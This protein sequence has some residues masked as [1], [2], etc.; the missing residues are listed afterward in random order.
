MPKMRD[1]TLEPQAGVRRRGPR[2]N[3][4]LAAFPTLEP[5]A[6]RL[7]TLRLERG[8]S[9]RALAARARISTNHYQDIAHAHANP[10]VIV[11][12]QLADAL[13]VQVAD[14]FDSPVPLADAHRRVLVTDLAELAAAHSRLTDIVERIAKDEMRQRRRLSKR[15]REVDAR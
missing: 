9:Q 2:Q 10:S 8:Y 1:S 3:R 7:E 6:K 15:R 12:L 11:L 5:F 4:E 13:G 14:L